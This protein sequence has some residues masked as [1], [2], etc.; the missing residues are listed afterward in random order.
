M[1]DLISA[2]QCRAARRLLGWSQEHLAGEA[3]LTTSTI[4]MFET[5]KSAPLKGTLINIRNTFGAAGIEF[6]EADV[7]LNAGP[8][9]GKR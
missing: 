4:G 1:E 6:G 5:G 3:N 2:V 8:Q 9:K 7:Q